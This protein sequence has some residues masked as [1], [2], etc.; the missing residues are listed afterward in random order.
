MQPPYEAVVFDLDGVVTDTASLHA[1]AWKSLFDE[2]LADPR[3]GR[4]APLPPFDVVQDYRRYVDGRPREDGVEAFLGARGI[5]VPR[6]RPDDP[7]DAWTVHGLARRKNE[8]FLALVATQGVRVFPGTAALLQRLRAAGTPLGLV[9]A[10]RNA[11]AL[12]V[13][14]GLA[15]AF[16]VVVDGTLAQRRALRGKPD[17]AT[18]LEAAGRRRRPGPRRGRRGR[19]RGCAG[20]A[21]RGFRPGGGHRPGRPA[22]RAGGAG[23]DF[24][25]DDVSELDLG[26]RRADPWLLVY[27]GFDP[28]HETHREALTT[29]GNGYLA[30]RGALPEH[31]AD[32]VHYPG[33]YLAGVYNRLVS[34]VD[35]EQRVDEDTGQRAQLAALDLAVEDGGWWSEGALAEADDRRELD[36]RRGLL[37]RTTTLSDD[38]GR[39]VGVVQRRLVSMQHPHLAATETVLTAHG[40]SGALRLRTGI[41]ASVVNANAIESRLLANRH[42]EPVGV[43]VAGDRLLV[44]VETSQSRIRIAT[45]VRTRVHA[46]GVG[47]PVLHRSASGRTLVEHRFELADGEPVV[48]DALAA[49]VTS[50]DVAIAS[51][52][53]GALTELDRV[54]DGFDRVLHGHVVAWRRLWE[55][56]AV[57]VDT[58]D[59]VQLSVNLH[60]F[61]VLQTLSPH[62]ADLDVGV[63]ARGLHGEAYRGHVFWDELF[64]LPLLNLHFPEVSRALLD[65]RHRRL[66]AARRA[67]RGRRP[68]GRDVPVAERQRRPRGDPAAAPQPAL[69]PLAARPLPP[70]A[71]RRARRSRTTSGSTARPPATPSSCTPRAPRCCWR[72]PGSGR[73]RPCS[74][75]PT[76]GTTSAASWAPTSTTTATPARRARPRRQRVHQRHRRLGAAPRAGAAARA[77]AAT[78]ATSSS[79]GSGSTPAELAPLG[80]RL[81]AG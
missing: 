73:T 51:P 75:R 12:L 66:D 44:E 53:D 10:S 39:R 36:L 5:E 72:S 41:D 52:R 80:G 28:A 6:G 46:A 11:G 25:L 21:P 18:F 49:V 34:T 37:T 67:A 17:P 24:V 77:A 23:A 27:E 13:A 4:D 22:P 62:T 69:R 63:P 61:H 55:H 59:P 50:R 60:L 74:T 3:A 38:A 81:A 64:V 16:D 40:W 70:P 58:D 19:R 1:A 57:D 43:E 68:P 56:F 65:Y 42:L 14:A 29:L 71:P 31:V 15:T 35:G 54:P 47:G 78:R 76:T 8:L 45:A 2:V 9:T 26:V 30:T 32:G 33:T 48:V 7:P 79:S 20:R